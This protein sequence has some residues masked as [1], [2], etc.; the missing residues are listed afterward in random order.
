[1]KL[2]LKLLIQ[3]IIILND[4]KEL[5][6]NLNEKYLNIEYYDIDNGSIF[7]IRERIKE[8]NN[9]VSGAYSNN[10]NEICLINENWNTKKME[11]GYIYDE[12]YPD[13][14]I[15]NHYLIYLY[16]KDVYKNA[17]LETRYEN[18]CLTDGYPYKTMSEASQKFG[19]LFKDIGDKILSDNY[20]D[21]CL[22]DLTELNKLFG[23][24]NY[25]LRQSLNYAYKG[26]KDI[27]NTFIQYI[28]ENDNM[29]SLLNCKFVGNNKLIMMNILYT[30]L[31]TYIETIGILT[32]M[33]SLSI[34]IGIVFILII[35]KNSKLDK[36]EDFQN[37]INALSNILKGNEN[38]TRNQNIIDI[39]KN[40]ELIKK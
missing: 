40:L 25:Y 16:D 29:F 26:M 4:L 28:S 17:R 14:D 32:I 9:Y 27:E 2:L 10:K 13:P 36:K 7:N 15:N 33:F 21:E 22:N 31:G 19:I 20:I 23:Q 18:S 3:L 12:S 6:E 34:F 35:I 8:I 5:N 37:D 24:K 39:E 1:M 11:E 38:E 30:S